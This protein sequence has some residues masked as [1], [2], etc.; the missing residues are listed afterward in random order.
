MHKEVKYKPAIVV[1][2]YNRPHSLTR[3]LSSLLRMKNATEV[4]LVI[5]ID[6]GAPDN[7]GVRDIAESFEW[8]FGEKKVFYQEEKLGLRKHIIKCADLSQK[9]CS[10]IILEDDLYV[11]PYFYDYAVHALNFYGN[12]DIET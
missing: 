3:I 5:S 11:S 7:F 10:V 1:V 6:N 4:E 2:A 12:D 9:Y 8:T